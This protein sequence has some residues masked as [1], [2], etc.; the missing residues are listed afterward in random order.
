ME[1]EATNQIHHNL[2]TT[3]EKMVLKSEV[4]IPIPEKLWDTDV[5]ANNQTIHSEEGLYEKFEARIKI[6]EVKRLDKSQV[7]VGS[8]INEASASATTKIARTHEDC[9]A[10]RDKFMSQIEKCEY[11]EEAVLVLHGA[12]AEALD[13][14][15]KLLAARHKKIHSSTSLT[16][17]AILAKIER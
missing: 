12:V 5:I 9:V 14:T 3:W 11:V 2:I 7:V 8:P 16:R 1:S 17:D 4:K 6:P 13:N 15:I 10:L